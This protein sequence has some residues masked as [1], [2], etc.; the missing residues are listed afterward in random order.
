MLYQHINIPLK[1]KIN[2]GASLF[3]T[4][5][6]SRVQTF[7]EHKMK[8]VQLDVT[9]CGENFRGNLIHFCGVSV[10]FDAFYWFGREQVTS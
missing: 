5:T 2:T 1:C 7:R 3:P 9:L 10:C 8:V 6:S 4:K